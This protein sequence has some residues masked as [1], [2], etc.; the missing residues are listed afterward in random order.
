MNW[1]GFY[2]D[3]K[4]VASLGLKWYKVYW[5]ENLIVWTVFFV[6]CYIIWFICERTDKV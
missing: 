5:L 6:V 3:W 2:T 1:L 4:F